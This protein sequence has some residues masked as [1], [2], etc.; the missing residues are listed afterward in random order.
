MCASKFTSKKSGRWF[1]EG[2]LCPDS[3]LW[4]EN[5]PKPNSYIPFIK[6]GAR[7]RL[8]WGTA[9]KRTCSKANCI[10]NGIK[11]EVQLP[12]PHPPLPSNIEHLARNPPS[13]ATPFLSCSGQKPWNHL[14][15]SAFDPHST[16]DVSANLV[17]SK[18]IQSPNTSHR[19][20]CHHPS[21]S[22]R[23][24]HPGICTQPCPLSLPLLLPCFQAI[25][26]VA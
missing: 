5:P 9:V 26:Y 22:H 12:T 18:Y 17:R 19:L 23:H 6:S 8:K 1:F 15:H 14:L 4:W 16:S 13:T 20:P 25:S 3:T 21:P 2:M 24:L 11:S 7:L 10:S